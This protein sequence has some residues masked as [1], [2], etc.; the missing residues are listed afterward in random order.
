MNII[1]VLNSLP[2]PKQAYGSIGI[3]QINSAEL[4][5]GFHFSPEYKEFLQYV[6]ALI[7][8]GNEI[9]GIT[10]YPTLD[11]IKLTV[12][13]RNNDP[14]LPQSMYVVSALHI[15]GILILQN[16]EGKVFEYLPLHYTKQ[17]FNSLADYIQSL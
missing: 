11:V 9:C 15:D 5:L 13:A 7:Y 4:K 10:P 6:G 17:I 8:K 3:E 1:D 16:L 2:M 14:A 12:E